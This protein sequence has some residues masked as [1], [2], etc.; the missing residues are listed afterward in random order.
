[1]EYLHFNEISNFL[2]YQP[3]QYLQNCEV[4]VTLLETGKFLMRR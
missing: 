2:E 3:L 4:T 1:M